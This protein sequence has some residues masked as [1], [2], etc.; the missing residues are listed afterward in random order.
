MRK[1][2]MKIFLISPVR[3]I[4]EDEKEKI[5]NYVKTLERGGNIVHWPF[6][7]INQNDIIGNRILDDNCIAMIN[8]DEIHIWWNEKSQGS[9]F[10]LGM[11]WIL[12]KYTKRK[13]II[14]NAEEIIP[15]TTKSFNNVVLSIHQQ[16]QLKK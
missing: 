16:N 7:D 12:E 14:A 13:I 2:C 8:S 9:V 10:D 6:R 15:T 1:G 3:N 5:F 11:A 4:T